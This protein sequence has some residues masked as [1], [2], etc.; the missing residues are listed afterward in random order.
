MRQASIP[1]ENWCSSLLNAASA[2][3]LRAV[4]LL[5]IVTL[6]LFLP[7]F[8]S[9]PPMDRDEP[10]FAQA[11]KQMLETGDAVDI[12]F[13]AESR[14]KKPVGIYWLQAGAVLVAEKLGVGD[15]REHI[16]LY[17]MPSLIGA[18]LAVLLTYWAGLPFMRPRNALLAALLFGATILLG[19]EARLAKTDAVIAASVIACMGVVGRLY[20]QPMG[21]KIPFAWPAIFWTAMALG[22]LVKGPITPLIVV[23]AIVALS[24]YERSGHWLKGLRPI[25]GIAWCLLLVAPWFVLIMMKT[26]L[27]FF[28]EAI[29]KDMLGKVAG[30]Q[31]AHGA[32]PGTY[33][34]AFWGTGWP[35]APFAALSV[36]FIW[37]LR[38]ERAVVFL[39]AWLVPTWLVF[40]ATPTKLPHYVLP[41]YPAIALSVG[42]ALENGALAWKARWGRA[43]LWLIPILPM[44]LI[45][46]VMGAAY[47]LNITPERIFLVLAL[48]VL[49]QSVRMLRLIHLRHEAETLVCEAVV[50][51]FIVVF[52]AF[53]GVMTTR[54]FQPFSLSPN[55][56]LARQEALDQSA[57]CG[58]MD[59][60][61]VG[62]REP[63][64][65]FLTQT[66]LLM[67]DAKGAASFLDAE[68]CRVVF[69]D[70]KSES[71]F[72][73]ALAQKP[74][75][76]LVT[77][78]RGINLNGGKPLDIG[79]YIGKNPA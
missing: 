38:K 22:I 3:H 75:P 73:S 47:K 19:V 29:G 41:L 40:E 42:L 44:L 36:P 30:G 66:D 49:V 26:G 28:S 14:Y 34:A 58:R 57:Q 10:R 13:Q 62:Y 48:A 67:T 65:V 61:T 51:S 43:M 63:S 77:R 79:V 27:S 15:A 12:R 31:E 24:I 37:L 5:F 21:E 11:T 25:A 18:I 32:W 17:R 45:G 78:V 2:T 59:P 71:E 56:A 50:L 70:A 74:S 76:H 52:M 46:L 33:L 16:W 55:L 20:L 39:M 8:A 9:L 6:G 54:M 23:L 35:L 64:L 72:L 69:I 4:C 60:A 7:G 53:S 1:S 68:P